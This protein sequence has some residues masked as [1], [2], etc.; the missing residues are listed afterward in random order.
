[1]RATVVAIVILLVLL[2]GGPPP[3]WAQGPVPFLRTDDARFVNLPE[4]PFPPNYVFVDGLRMHYVDSGPANGPVVL[5]LHGEPSWSFLYRKMIPI[6]AGAG[7]RVVAPD[8]IGFG[9]SDKPIFR[10]DYS[11][12]KHVDWVTSL[13][14]Q[15]DLG[16]ITL[17]CQ[18][19]G[20][21]IG[22]RV[23][24]DLPDRFDRIVAAN[25]TLL[26]GP[27]V[28]LPPPAHPQPGG[29][30]FAEWLEFSQNDVEFDIGFVADEF[31][32]ES[33]LSE[34]VKDG[35]RAP[36]PDESYKAG[37]R[38]FPTLVN[39]EPIQNA[40]AW[41][42]LTRLDEPFL[43][44]FSDGDRVTWGFERQFIEH[45]PGAIG[46]PHA[47]IDGG[48]F[49]QE[50]NG[51]ELANLIV[52]WLGGPTAQP[53]C[54][55]LD[56]A[57]IVASKLGL[58]SGDEKIV[59]R[60]EAQLAYPFG[61][62]L[63]PIANGVRVIVSGASGQAI[64]AADLPEGAFDPAT[65]VGW[66]VNR[67]GNRWRYRDS[68]ATPVDGITKVV[69]KDRSSKTPGL[70][71]VTLKGLG[72]YSI[73]E[74]DLPLRAAVVLDPPAATGGQCARRDFTSGGAG[75]SVVPSGSRVICR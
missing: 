3:V 2:V 17:V 27:P 7:F 63:D 49:L 35:Y 67:A 21:L 15:L 29:I 26:S 38:V 68:S 10:P 75:C 57:R 19:W 20:G 13:I 48:H 50:D 58:P 65:G 59:L 5:L 11:H 66:T 42:V 8:L 71:K 52:S 36:F 12:Q 1:M 40:A 45:V 64:V 74:S 46:Q 37:A 18:D 32:T 61:P 47:V 9:R 14:E 39:S 4:Y 69:I 28:S 60:G 44:L 43:T 55:T 25:T 6:L 73:G 70:V 30:G 41:S 22:L 24:T 34:A 62:V 33:R 23:A 54:P 51:E 53:L 72:S 56:R 16:G 31:A